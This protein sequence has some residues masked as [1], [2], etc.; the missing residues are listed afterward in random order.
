[1]VA[2]SFAFASPVAD[3]VN[4]CVW[5]FARHSYDVGDRIQVMDKVLVVRQIFLTHT[6]FEEHKGD[7]K[8]LVQISHAKLTGEALVNI[9]RSEDPMEDYMIATPVGRSNV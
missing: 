5:V 4:S 1:M 6:N 8:Q 9:T 3:L 7:K 2:L